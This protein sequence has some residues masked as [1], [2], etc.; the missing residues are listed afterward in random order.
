MFV[1]RPQITVLVP[2]HIRQIKIRRPKNTP[3]Q[4]YLHQFVHIDPIFVPTQSRPLYA[5]H[6]GINRPRRIQPFRIA[7]PRIQRFVLFLT[8][9]IHL[10]PRHTQ[11]IQPEHFFQTVHYNVIPI[12]IH[13]LSTFFQTNL[14]PLV[15]RKEAHRLVSTRSYHAWLHIFQ[16]F[17]SNRLQC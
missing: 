4:S 16:I 3:K 13:T 17:K 8:H 11:I 6:H 2:Q 15:F 12:V 9:F 5:I 1:D 7:L 10:Y 14:P